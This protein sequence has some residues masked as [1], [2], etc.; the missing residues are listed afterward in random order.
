MSLIKKILIGIF[1]L[2]LLI[3]IAIGVVVATVDPNDYRDNITNVVKDK[4]GR[5]LHFDNIELAFFPNIGA[6]LEN[7]T[8]SNAEGFEDEQFLKVSKIQISI[9]IM[10]LFKSQLEI[11]TLTLHGLDVRLARN[12]GGITN[13]DD[14]IKSSDQTPEAE[15]KVADKTDE[16]GESFLDQLTSLNFG[17]LDIRNGQVHWSDQQAKQTVNL[18]DFN[19]VT[20]AITFGEFFNIDLSAHTKLSEPD[21]SAQVTLNLDAKFDKN[22]AFEVKNLKQTNKLNGKVIPVEELITELTI[23]TLNINLEQEQISL[24][25]V[26]L[27][28]AVKGGKD[29]PAKNLDGSLNIANLSANLK[30]QIFA[31]DTVKISYNLK[32]DGSIP[33]DTAK[34]TLS[35]E[36]PSFSMADESL[37][38]GLLTLQSDL[39]GKELPNGKATIQLSTQPALNLKADTALLSNLKLNALDLKATGA[40]NIAKLTNDPNVTANLDVPAF[41]LRQLLKQLGLDIPAVNE[42]SDKTTLTKVAAKLNVN[43]DSKTEAVSVK[44]IQITLDDSAV[45]GSASVKS[46]DKPAIVYDLNLDKI[47]V[48]RYLP[49]ATETPT[50]TP[51]AVK[52]EEQVDVEIPLP[53]ELLKTLN[54]NGTLKAGSVQYDKLNPTNIVMVV[55]AKDGLININP[56]KTDMFKTQINATARLDVRATQPNYAVTF[57]TQNLPIGDVLVAFMDDDKISGIGS[58]N[59][60]LTTSGD[61]LS[62]IKKGLNGTLSADLKDGAVKGFNIAQSIRQAKEKLGK[63]TTAANEELKTDFSSLTGHFVIKNGVVDTKTLQA[64]APFMRI[65]GSGTVNLVE[66]TL[67]Y[68]VKAKIVATGKGQGGDELKEL[69]GLTIPVKLKGALD[70][71]NVSL[72]LGSLIEQKAKEEVKQK[73]EEKKEEVKEKL[74]NKLKD[75]LL[76]RLRF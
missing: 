70:A 14:L 60:N 56:L 39:T 25:K 11:D 10:P 19:F 5:D 44:N 65:D 73:I 62:L 76:N 45:T 58:V 21:L 2:I 24:P 12:A 54:I 67:D 74:E 57:N 28:Y 63:K 29:F 43:F 51:V 26:D 8:L 18:T 41:N 32:S 37:T 17:G 49:P 36:N 64:Q 27:T 33:I 13:W 55:K 34:G 48:S 35:L 6:N 42:M 72:D 15:E 20:S 4:T 47:N 52:S 69:N 3:V 31:T 16:V 53:T 7:V 59:A 66:E 71:P 38:S 1:S 23:P 30:D 75:G 68:L 61:R 46:F 9:A 40:V 50:E 22:G